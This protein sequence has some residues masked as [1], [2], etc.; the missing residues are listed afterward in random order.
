LFDRYDMG[1]EE[2]VLREFDIKVRGINFGN[3][4]DIQQE[5]IT[6]NS[7]YF[8]GIGAISFGVDRVEQLA[9]DISTLDETEATVVLISDAGVVQAGIVERVKSILERSG[10]NVI[11]FS[12]IKG[13]PRA[14][15]VEEA[16]A[17][18]RSCDHPCVVGLGGGSALD[19]AKLAA[20]I[21][22]DDRPAEDYSLCAHPFPMPKL[23]RIM[24]PT[25]AGTGSEVTRTAI[26]TTSEKRKVWTFGNE[27][28][29]DLVILDP[30]LTVSLP[31]AMTAISGLDALVHA[32]EA[33]T[34]QKRNPFTD[35]LG[36]HAIRLVKQH[37]INAIE[38][39]E[40]MIARSGMLLASTLAGSA[41]ASTG[42]AAAHSIGHAL[43]TIAEIPHGK[44]VAIGMD[45]LLAWNA[46]AAPG[47]HAAVAEALGSQRNADAASP[48]FRSLIDQTRIDRSLADKQIDSDVLAAVMMSAEN[49]PMLENNARQI[50]KS[51]A[52]E[53]ARRTLGDKRR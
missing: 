30:R 15:E 27:L 7:F 24:I 47:A 49:V 26:F 10:Q 44:A 1:V 28:V 2:E 50:T 35:S 42:T 6:M 51:D 3:P 25:T 5:G 19:V 20:V 46:E 18:V 40:D 21:A 52:L 37:L 23:K 13:E 41:F 4:E 33:C 8:A 12:N 38:K 17:I 31:A 32:I 9:D 34:C 14:G 16:T 48:A 53:L 22:G 39:P 29:P 36:L 45:I 11:V 43:G